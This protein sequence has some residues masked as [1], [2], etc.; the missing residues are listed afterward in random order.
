MFVY[1]ERA[2]VEHKFIFLP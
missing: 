1:I 2:R